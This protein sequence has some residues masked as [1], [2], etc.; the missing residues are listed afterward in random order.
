MPKV[1][2]ARDGTGGDDATRRPESGEVCAGCAR[3]IEDRF[4]LRVSDASWHERCLQCAA[5]RQP[6]TR[7]CYTRE[8]RNYCRPDYDKLFGRKCA[9]CMG[10]V[11][12]SELVM[13]ALE[14][15]YHLGCFSCCVC[16]RPLRK[17][18]EFVLKEG[19]LFCRPDY[20]RERDMLS[21]ASPDASDSVKSEDE[22]GVKGSPGGAPGAK[23]GGGG[24]GS[25]S[26]EKDPKRPKRPRTILTTQQRR[27]FKA[28]FEVS[29]KP[30]RKVRESLA[31]ETGLSVRVVQVWFQNQRA[32]MKKLARRQIQQEQGQSGQ[33]LGPGRGAAR[34]VRRMK[35]EGEVMMDVF[36][37]SPVDMMSG[38]MEGMMSPFTQLP[39]AHVMEAASSSYQP[40]PFQQGLTPPQMPGDAM[41]PYG[42]DPMFQEMEGDTSLSGLSDCL[43]AC[44]EPITAL[45]PR[46]G[47][48]IDRLYSMQSS[49]FTS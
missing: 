44:V 39:H 34:G 41:N 22:D 11:A 15:V 18:D 47:N 16:E 2:V 29:S 13:R 27:A 28:S 26:D 32:K 17:G 7:S 45:Q 49:Y 24:G 4:L 46:V 43:L 37:P 6:L 14:S 30:C 10:S 12:P 40:D 19:Q 25:G 42:S 21:S 3:P 33:R 23:G 36:S 9:G 5:C 31:A 20:E 1:V 8:R 48:P 35:E 38:A